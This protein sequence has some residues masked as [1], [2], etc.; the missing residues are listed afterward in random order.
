[1]KVR[2]LF[3]IIGSLLLLLLAACTTIDSDSSYLLKSLD[4][5]NKSMALT[6][7]GVAAY[8]SY[9]IAQGD[10]RKADLVRQ[11][12]VVALRYDPGN[13]KAAQY[14]DKV[15]SFKAGLARDKLAAAN[16][17]LAKPAR[18]DDENYA[19][20]A[21]LQTAVTVD[22]SNDAASKLL[23]D[24][25]P[26][27]NS[28][29]GVYLGRSKDAQTKAADPS[30]SD[31]ARE[32]LYIQ[33]YDSASKAAN[34]GP[35]NAQAAKQKAAIQA[36]LEKAFTAHQTAATRLTGLDKF[37]DAK[38]ELGR[39]TSIDV[40]LGRLHG[41][42]VAALTYS[43]YF[44]WAT[45]L[46]AKASYQDAE[47]KVDIALTAKRSEDAMALK[48]KLDLKNA[49]A[50]KDASFDAALPEIDK[51]IAKGDY[52]AANKRIVAAARVTKDK[53]KLDQLDTRKAKITAALSDI[54]DKGVAAYKAEDFKTAIDQLSVVVGIDAE[55]QQAS[56]YLDKAKEKQKLL[57]QYSN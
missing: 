3:P 53:A 54:Y 29:V 27:Q 30:L 14:L 5:S 19:A 12:F 24:N 28:L 11:Y 46:E 1:M 45:S 57:D 10:Y 21:A 35:G 56:D 43:L 33:A 8:D 17:L 25:A 15:D 23:K 34:L 52:L 6:T 55:Y 18:T 47:A 42:A 9:L 26:V 51:S 38:A 20:I 48:K 2:A 40:R 4:D 50:N 36:D 49:S 32:A 16:T 22:P 13:P 41:D 7:Q 37:D 39:A 44:A 31:S